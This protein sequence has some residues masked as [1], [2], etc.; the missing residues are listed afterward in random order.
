MFWSLQTKIKLTRI[1]SICTLLGCIQS[2]IS[3]LLIYF[4]K[5]KIKNQKKYT[6]PSSLPPVTILKPL[7]NAEPLLYE[8]LQSFC[9]QDY[10]DFQLIFGVQDKK[11]P[12]IE[13]V[14]H[15]QNQYPNR[16]IKL[17]INPKIHGV[18]RKVS[19][20]INMFAYAIHDCLLISDSDIHTPHQNYLRETIPLLD[21]D[22]VGLITSLYSG[23][24]YESSIVQMLASAHINYN[25]MPGVILSR[26]LG[27]QDCF[28]ACVAIKRS[29]LMKIGGLKALLPY[30][31]DDAKLGELIRKQN[32]EVVL[33]PSIVKTTVSENTF[34]AL[35][36]HELRW[37]RTVFTVEPLGFTCSFIQ[38]P[39]FWISLAVLLNPL[40]KKSWINFLSCWIFQSICCLVINKKIKLDLK[41][42]P[43]L[44]PLRDWISASIMMRS[45]FKED[46]EWR[47]QKMTFKK[48][49][50]SN[51]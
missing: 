2:G 36:K 9:E 1:L 28:G 49:Q 46:I 27:R 3:C 24:P 44:L 25:F 31:A 43:F 11:D 5:K 48:N 18:N 37:N 30:I 6:A 50:G 47:G 17:V 16:D 20:L 22:N 26:Y 38:L 4:F 12:A 8:A 7:A 23:L 33:S 40:K 39:L 29:I 15:L 51:S 13:I 35:Y 41:L 45:I 21:N 42:I 10:P 32:L 19:N 34:Q 14:H